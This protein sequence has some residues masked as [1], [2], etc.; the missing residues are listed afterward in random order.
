MDNLSNKLHKIIIVCDIYLL[1]QLATIRHCNLTISN[2]NFRL[3]KNYHVI[4]QT[5]NTTASLVE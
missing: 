2:K 1:L 5:F 4:G 3:S